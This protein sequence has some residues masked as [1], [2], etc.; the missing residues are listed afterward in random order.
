VLPQL[1][2]TRAAFPL[3]AGDVQSLPFA[4]A[5][6]DV[7]VSAHMLYHVPDVPAA[8]RELHRVLRPGGHLLAIYD[9]ARS[10]PEVDDL[11]L[12]AGGT[13]T[14]NALATT[15][16]LESAPPLLEAEFS[17][18]T[19]HADAGE[20][21]VPE[22]APVLD[23]IDGLRPIAEPFL[24]PRR[25]LGRD[26]GGRRGAGRA[27]HRRSGRVPHHRDQGRVRL[28]GV[29][30]SY[31]GG[32]R[33]DDRAGF[34]PA[35]V[36][37]G[38]AERAAGYDRANRF[39]AEDL[40]ELRRAG[41]LGA[42]VPADMGGAGLTLPEVARQ[43][44]RVA[45]RGASTA[46]GM[47]M[48]LTCTGM[49]ADLRRGG[50]DSLA[51]VLRDAA[52][53]ELFAYAFSEAGN[54]GFWDDSLTRAEP[55]ADGAYSFHGRKIFTSMSPAWTRLALFGRDD[56]DPAGP[57]VVH[58][59]ID[60]DA[61]GWRVEE[62]WDTQAMRA[63]QSHTT[64][65]EGVRAPADRVVRRLPVGPQRDPMIVATLAWFETLIAA[66]YYGI[67]E[68]AL[69]LATEAV[70]RRTSLIAGG[71]PLAEDPVVRWRLGA[72]ALEL[73][74]LLPQIERVATDWSGG[75]DHGERWGAEL[76]GLK[77]RVTTAAQRVVEAAVEVTGGAAM[78]RS[79]EL[80]RLS[81]DV[82]AGQFHPANP[83]RAHEVL[84]ST[85]LDPA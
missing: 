1:R 23:E 20:M 63:T 54:D 2:A 57:K 60:R 66:V 42:A 33:N 73:D 82:R 6:L 8:L 31:P 81:R 41:Y 30:G 59:V 36:L 61:P 85:L 64:M 32:V 51:F 15:F 52:A 40:D 13:T 77:H 3:V 49:A 74:G 16:S 25:G 12:S 71:R 4:T 50:D 47:N 65:L 14:L 56:A 19:L 68:R 79:Q 44:V 67:A 34:L 10:Q 83:Q 48:H 80:E 55:L 78:F 26:A 21:L 38:I 24:R 28:P 70:R 35:G 69:D 39:F 46:L 11:F 7:A 27:R 75:V 72:A 58:A 45:R 22:P 84:A 17:D 37:D 53:G 9:S 18:V 43:Q 62:S 29:S 5:S 76:V